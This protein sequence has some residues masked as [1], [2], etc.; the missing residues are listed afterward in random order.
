[1]ISLATVAGEGFLLILTLIIIITLATCLVKVY[2]RSSPRPKR[3]ESYNKLWVNGNKNSGGFPKTRFQLSNT[4]SRD[5]DE[6]EDFC[7]SQQPP[8]STIQTKLPSISRQEEIVENVAYPSLTFASIKNERKKDEEETQDGE[9][10]IEVEK[11][12]PLDMEDQVS[13]E[14]GDSFEEEEDEEEESEGG[15]ARD[16]KIPITPPPYPP[17]LDHFEEIYD[18]ANHGPRHICKS[19]HVKESASPDEQDTVTQPPNEGAM[20]A[21]VT[22]GEDYD[23]VLNHR[24]KKPRDIEDVEV[25]YDVVVNQLSTRKESVSK[26]SPPQPPVDAY[27]MCTIRPISELPISTSEPY[28]TL[29]VSTNEA[30]EP[31]EAAE[32]ECRAYDSVV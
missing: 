27:A 18:V 29:P 2:T 15:T 11:E 22:Q 5:E 3:S 8:S 26:V 24:I 13:G 19:T 4:D 31:H 30:Y 6:D 28:E 10:S 16:E 23:T 32:W 20:V 1:M 14:Y 17:N 21:M 12:H 7:P 9:V 25:I